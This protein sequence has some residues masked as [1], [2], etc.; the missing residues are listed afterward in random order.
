MTYSTAIPGQFYPFTPSMA[1]KLREANLSAAEWRF[2]CYLTEHDPWGDRY[3]ELDPLDI[4]RE[5]GMSKA[6]YYRA[7]AKLQ[8]LG[9]F[10]FQESKVSFRN[11]TGISKIKQVSQKSTSCLMVEDTSLKIETE[12][13]AVRQEPQE[14][15]KQPPKPSPRKDSKISQTLQTYSDL[16]K[17]LSEGERENFEK[18]CK[19][20]IEECGFKI[21]SRNAWLNKHGAEYLA[22]FQE[23]YSEALANP[24]K[25]APKVKPSDLVDLAWIKKFYGDNWEAAALHHGLILPNSPAVENQENTSKSEPRDTVD[26]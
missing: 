18:F 9:L 23:M 11:L 22:E 25:T 14:R 6:T 19:K 12:N 8:E 4:M 26:W 21:G 13:A 5:C 1:K 7:K 20:K 17:T 10:D 2:W 15:E 3:K 24:Q 16:L